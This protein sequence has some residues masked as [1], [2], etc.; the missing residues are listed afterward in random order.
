MFLLLPLF[1]VLTLGRAPLLGLDSPRIP[2]E[3]IVI[4]N[5]GIN[6]DLITKHQESYSQN[7][8]YTY[9][10][11]SEFRGFSARLNEEELNRVLD[12]PYV[13]VVHANGIEYAIQTCDTNQAAYSWGLARTSHGGRVNP[14]TGLPER[15]KYNSKIAGQGVYL[16]ILDTGIYREHREFATGRVREGAN[17]V[18]DGT[19]AY[20][21]QN[22]H[23]THCAG[24][25]G[26][27]EYGI[28]R[29]ASLIPVK[30]LGA[31][32]SGATSGVIKGI[33]YVAQNHA[34]NGGPSVGSMSLGSTSDGGKNAAI[35]AAVRQGSVFVVAAGNSQMDA[36]SYYPASC[37]DAITVGSTTLGVNNDDQ[38]SSFSNF[39][40]CVDIFA[41]GSNIVSAG[42]TSPTAYSTKSGTSMACPHVAGY[43]A[44]LLSQNPRLTPQAVK[45]EIKGN[46]NRN[47]ITSPGTGSPNEL[48]YNLC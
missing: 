2:D 11:S 12:T 8:I 15:F 33:E 6:S 29:L 27:N 35:T 32:G 10:I 20:V 34:A 13:K 47:I 28:A 31:S 24:T 4:Y 7:I 36:C 26:G 22:S 1:F 40:S 37:P 48:L 23:G 42:I 17:F 21:D 44:S 46:S 45:A 41:P 30:V 19:P 18:G 43:A 14:T 16:Y 5:D 9:N 25:A 39:G 38:R 3:Y